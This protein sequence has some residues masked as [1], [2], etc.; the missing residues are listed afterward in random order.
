M[1]AVLT[2]Y[3]VLRVQADCYAGRWVVEAF[4][5]HGIVVDQT[6][7]PKSTLYLAALPLLAAGWCDLLDL[8]RL[9]LQLAGLERRRRAGG[10]DIVDHPPGGHDDVANTVAGVVVLAAH[11]PTVSILFDD[12]LAVAE[13]DDAPAIEAQQLQAGFP[14]WAG[15]R[16][17]DQR[18]GTCVSFNAGEGVCQSSGPWGNHL[19]TARSPCCEWFDPLPVGE[20]ANLWSGF[21]GRR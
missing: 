3:G 10:R 17:P 2:A 7:E 4:R 21:P 5:P 6:A 18:C 11:P 20:D 13:D 19:V 8:P 12:A 9:R 1:A 16:D 14:Q 15:R